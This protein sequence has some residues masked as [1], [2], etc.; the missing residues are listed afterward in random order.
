MS[1]NDKNKKFSGS[2]EFIKIIDLAVHE[3]VDS[4]TIEYDD[5]GL[6]VCY[7]TG[8]TGI[9]DIFIDR[10]YEEVLIEYICH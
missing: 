6:E 10:D 8:I 5:D 1:K 9:A 4:I 7:W 3:S 2:S